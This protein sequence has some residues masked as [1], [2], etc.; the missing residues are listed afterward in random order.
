[1]EWYIVGI[2]AALLTTFG[3]VPQILKMKHSRSSKDVSIV[4]LYQFSA[5]VILWALYGLH[6]QD[7][8]IIAANSIT[9]ITLVVAIGFYHHYDG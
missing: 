3:F 8:I 1:M 5:G 4:T 7:H 6:I 2:L 9:L